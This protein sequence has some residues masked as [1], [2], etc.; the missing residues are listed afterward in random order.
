M[1]SMLPVRVRQT[2]R[3]LHRRHVL[4]RTLAA[5]PALGE[6][7]PATR[8]ASTL[9]ALVYGWGN[10]TFSARHDFLA[11]VLSYG[12]R[13]A[14]PIL[15]CGSGLS[16]VVLAKVSRQP[17]WSLEHDPRWRDRTQSA[18]ARYGCV[19]AQV[20]WAPLRSYG[21]FSWY[22]PPLAMMPNDFA[23]VVCDGPPSGT[24]GGRYGLL[25]VMRSRVRPGCVVLLDD[26][27]RDAEA[28]VAAR[29]VSEF[30]V[31]CAMAGER[32]RYAV[33]TALE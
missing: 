24:P 32:Q 12:R 33:L 11:A 10:E 23:L 26:A 27:G 3:M 13:A 31:T 21:M 6:A 18:L 17:V 16:T 22:D 2:L 20:V 1:R 28:L 25:A 14:G 4:R 29:W 30:R 8:T 9:E 15:E 7:T 5:L 19:Q